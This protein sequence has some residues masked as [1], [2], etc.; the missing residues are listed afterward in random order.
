MKESTGGALLMGLAAGIIMIFIIMVAFFISYGSTFKAKNAVINNIEQKEGLRK[1]DVEN[2]AVS[3]ATKYNPSNI[4]TCFSRVI[5]GG[6][7]V[8]FIQKVTIYMEFD[9]TILGSALNIR[10]PVKGETRIIEKGS[11]YEACKLNDSSCRNA[12]GS[13]NIC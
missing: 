13:M 2:Y 6:Q 3:L 5:T 1:V 12:L 11:I 10:I 4:D 9:K 8:G 7:Y